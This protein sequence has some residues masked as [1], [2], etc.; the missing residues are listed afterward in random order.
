MTYHQTAA[1]F[2]KESL[3][4]DKPILVE[5]LPLLKSAGVTTNQ[6]ITANI[7]LAWDTYISVAVVTYVC[8]TVKEALSLIE[9]NASREV[10]HSES[11]CEEA[12]INSLEE[13][14]IT[15]SV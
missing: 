1:L 7:Q 2:T 15:Q 3:Y 4:A 14:C 10:I 5:N 11:D 8:V 6:V 13:V 12:W 9:M